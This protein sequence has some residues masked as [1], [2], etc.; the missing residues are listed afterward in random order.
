MASV[1]SAVVI[2]VANLFKSRG[3]LE[4]ENLLLRHQLN[5][6]LR[7]AL[8][9]LRLR[10]IDRALL[11]GLIRFWPDLT[12]ALQVAKPE[13]VLRWHRMGFRAYWRWKSQKRAGR[14]RIDCGLRDLIR[15]CAW[16]TRC[17]VP[18]PRRACQA[19]FRGRP[20]DGLEIYGP[21]S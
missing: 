18:N 10:G 16:T 3:R 12:S 13:T 11:V 9:R 7:H 2:F 15:K 14:P 19:G 8:A 4:A 5:V 1:L 17:G 6:A 21:R 20:V